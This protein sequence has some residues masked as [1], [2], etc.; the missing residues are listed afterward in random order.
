MVESLVRF[1]SVRFGWLLD[2]LCA[3]DGTRGGSKGVVMEVSLSEMREEIGGSG[4]QFFAQEVT[5]VD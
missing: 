3:E 4:V 1:G 2:V 5:S